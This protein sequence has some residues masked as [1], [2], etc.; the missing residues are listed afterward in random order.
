M[1]YRYIKTPRSISINSLEQNEYN[2]SSS[3]YMDL[4]IPNKNYLYIKD[5]LS[6]PLKRSDLG[7]EVGSINYI[8]KSSYYFLRTKALQSH[9]FLPEITF[10]SALPILPKAFHNADLKE[11]DLLISKDSNIGE[12]VILD[13]NYANYMLSGAIYK[14]PVTKHKYYLLAFIKHQ[15]FRE[16]IDFMVPK[17]ATIRHAKTMF[18]DC[19][20]PMPNINTDDTIEFVEVLTK[21]IINKE[22]LIKQKHSE[23]LKTFETELRENQKPNQFKYDFPTINEVSEIG[24][25]DTS[26]Y[27]KKYKLYEFLIKNYEHGHFK[28]SDCGYKAKRGQNLQLSNIG[29]SFYSDVPHKGFYKLAVSSNFSEYSTI[30]KLTYLGNKR[31][32]SLIQKGDI[33]FSARGAQFGRVVVFPENVDNTI[34]NI[35]SL[36]IQNKKNNLTRSIFIALFLNNLRWNRHIYDIAIKGSGANSLTQYQSDDINFPNFP[37]DKQKEIA[38]LY[39]NLNIEEYISKCTLGNFLTTDDAYNKNAGIYELDKTS[40]KLKIKLNQAIED[41][42]YDKQVNISFDFT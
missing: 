22:K 34:T 32:L 12:I 21:A 28:L 9:S 42:I 15:I 13:K 31:D 6:R 7:I 25:L 14:L 4:V 37:E 19:K 10:E 35:D 29:Q 8:G 16:Q 26:R 33:I 24:R 40:K 2:L 20:I 36:V 23:I 1:S 41:I 3:Q 17:G 11:G 39:Y 38:K 18:L 27:S 30:E 5:F